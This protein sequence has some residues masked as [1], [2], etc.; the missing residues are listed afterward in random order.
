MVRV[1][2][3]VIKQVLKTTHIRAAFAALFCAMILCYG[4]SF[5]LY[6]GFDILFD[7]K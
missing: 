6:V 5:R 7:G 4:Y 3:G 2:Y 1:K